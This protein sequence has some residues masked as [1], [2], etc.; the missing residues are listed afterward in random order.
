[1]VSEMTYLD[2]VLKESLRI[3]PSVP[4]IAR[5]LTADLNVDGV[6][7]PKGANVG[8]HIFLIHRSPFVWENPSN[9][10]PERW[11]PEKAQDL[12]PYQHIPFSAGFFFLTFPL[13][14]LFSILLI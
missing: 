13:N 11:S 3:Y 1:M 7:I 14:F 5:T 2:M 8:I 12:D 6:T 4:T 10:D 9:F